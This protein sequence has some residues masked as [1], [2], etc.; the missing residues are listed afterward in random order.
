MNAGYKMGTGSEKGERDE[1]GKKEKKEEKEGE[2][3]W[4]TRLSVNYD[5]FSI[6]GLYYRQSGLFLR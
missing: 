2:E 5:T 3:K 4:F 1:G 6:F